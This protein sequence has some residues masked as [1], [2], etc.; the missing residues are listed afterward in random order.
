VERGTVKFWKLSKGWGF[1]ARDGG[2]DIFIHI[3]ALPSGT[4]PQKGDR[5][6]FTP[7][8]LPDGRLR[9][10]AATVIERAG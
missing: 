2:G 1:L 4:V 8:Q 5:V 10:A 3:H 7:E 6:L 9:A